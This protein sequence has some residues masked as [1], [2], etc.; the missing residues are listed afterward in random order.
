M[1]VHL[2]DLGKSLDEHADH[3][4]PVQFTPRAY[5]LHPIHVQLQYSDKATRQCI[6]LSRGFEGLHSIRIQGTPVPWTGQ[7]YRRK[8]IQ[9]LIPFP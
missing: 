9:P 2:L 7:A 3:V 6:G 5:L 1:L 8:A 4:R